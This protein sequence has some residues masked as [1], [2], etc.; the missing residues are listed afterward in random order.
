MSRYTEWMRY[1]ARYFPRKPSDYDLSP[2]AFGRKLAADV[3]RAYR[4]F[5]R[6]YWR[7]EARDE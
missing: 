3:G 2:E 6:R 7:N 4:R 5:W 1:K